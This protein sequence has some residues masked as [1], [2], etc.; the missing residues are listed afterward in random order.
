MLSALP[1][2]LTPHPRLQAAT[3]G[4]SYQLQHTWWHMWMATTASPSSYLEHPATPHV[5]M[6][7]SGGV[8]P[9]VVAPVGPRRRRHRRLPGVDTNDSSSYTAADRG[10]SYNR[11]CLPGILGP[12]RSRWPLGL[13]T[14][15]MVAT[16][17]TPDVGGVRSLTQRQLGAWSPSF[18]SGGH[19]AGGPSQGDGHLCLHLRATDVVPA[20]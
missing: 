16:P 12:T 18:N 19:L 5:G 14:C 20:C 9:T 11:T 1:A 7:E 15:P 17:L 13:T 3:E 8:L 4:V 6:A 2:V 10:E